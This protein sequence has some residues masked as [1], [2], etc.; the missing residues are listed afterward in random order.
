MTDGASSSSASTS[1]RSIIRESRWGRTVF[2]LLLLFSC[3]WMSRLVF[4]LRDA[5]IV[6]GEWGEKGASESLG[7]QFNVEGLAS[8]GSH[9]ASSVTREWWEILA[10]LLTF[11]VC[12]AALRFLD[13]L[14]PRAALAEVGLRG[15]LPRGWGRLALVP[16][17]PPLVW[18]G[19]VML[20]TEGEFRT[21]PWTWNE[22]FFPLSDTEGTL[23]GAMFGNR[24]ARPVWW[25]NG[26]VVAIAGAVLSYG[27]V[28]KQLRRLGFSFMATVGLYMLV[29][30]ILTV[31][32]RIWYPM[33][34]DPF[35]LLTAVL[36]YL[37][38]FVTAAVSIALTGWI[39][40]QWGGRV[41]V[42]ALV[43]L[44]SQLPFLLGFPHFRSLAIQ[45]SEEDLWLITGASTFY[46]FGPL[47]LLAVLTRVAPRL[48]LPPIPRPG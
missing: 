6:A 36:L 13:G 47:I 34:I 4:T 18:L 14:R 24:A 37:F 22:Y 11:G 20:T 9:I 43:T 17:L 29:T 39:F 8:L 25:L 12:L 1:W 42:P 3:H 40:E 16:L 31:I 41:W 45:G 26:G 21:V 32:E 35:D 5:I 44:S 10:G 48:G 46:M 2:L 38:L 15:G 19:Y 23:L 33:S 30:V 27:L 7:N 28:W